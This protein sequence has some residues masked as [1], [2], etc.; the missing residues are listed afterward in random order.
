M[1]QRNKKYNPKQQ[2]SVI[3]PDKGSVNVED[4]IVLTSSN[5]SEWREQLSLYFQHK[6]A[7]IGSFLKPGPNNAAPA[8]FQRPALRTAAAWEERRVAMGGGITE[9][10]IRK[11]RIVEWTKRDDDEIADQKLLK[12]WFPTILKTLSAEQREQLALAP[13][14][15]AVN[16]AQLPLELVDLIETTVVWGISGLSNTAQADVLFSFYTDKSRMTQQPNEATSDYVRRFKA[17]YSC[18]VS[19]AHPQRGDMP[20]AIR[21]CVQGL[22]KQ[23]HTAYCASVSNA[24]NSGVANAY[25]ASFALIASKADIFADPY[26]HGRSASAPT[27]TAPSRYA[28]ACNFCSKDGHD[29]SNCWSKYP[30]QLPPRFAKKAPQ[31][32]SKPSS[33]AKKSAEPAASTV[34]KSKKKRDKKKKNVTAYATAVTTSASA[35]SVSGEAMNDLWGFTAFPVSVFVASHSDK[36]VNDRLLTLD[37]FANCSFCANEDLISDIREYSF[38]VKGATGPGQGTH[39]GLLPGFGACAHLP[40]AGVN[41][42]SIRDA[43]RYPNTVVQRESWTIHMSPDFDLTMLW[44]EE[45]G[46][47][48][49][50]IDDDMLAAMKSAGQEVSQPQSVD[51]FASSIAQLERSYPKSEIK[52]AKEV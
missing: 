31:S 17:I 9:A 26:G 24:E 52:A 5:A 40:Q 33:E 46:H 18:L 51:V 37:S 42:L 28:F 10:D 48:S 12:S 4:L 3:K 25:P 20:S 8:Y 39:M 27:A 49:V 38:G 16:L 35:A 21:K 14:W 41:A 22:D 43:Y 11:Q 45:N 47:Y 23:R 15:E 30:D 2:A 36:P 6:D 1:Y 29:E 32:D 34:S 13:T 50:L 19:A 44:D 7:E